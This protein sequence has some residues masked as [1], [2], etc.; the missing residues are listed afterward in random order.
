MET[1]RGEFDPETL[2]ILTRAFD[3]AWRYLQHVLEDRTAEDRERL[4]DIIVQ[5]GRSGDRT[6]IRIANR[7]VDKFSEETGGRFRSTLIS[8]RRSVHQE[9]VQVQGG[10]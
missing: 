5:I 3:L 9:I 2:Q 1:C 6:T 10:A 7:A 8:E 4:T